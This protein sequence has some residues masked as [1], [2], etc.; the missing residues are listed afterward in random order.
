MLTDL[1]ERIPFTKEILLGTDIKVKNA[2]AIALNLGDLTYPQIVIRG[3]YIGGSDDL[4]ELIDK[5]II[6]NLLTMNRHLVGIN[7]TVATVGG[8]SDPSQTNTAI[9]WYEPL[10]KRSQTPE[11]LTIPGDSPYFSHW[12]FFQGYMYSNLVRYISIA[13]SIILALCLLLAPFASNT[14]SNTYHFLQIAISFLLI[15][16]LGILLFGPSPFSFSGVLSTYFGWKYKGNTTSS[17]PYKFVWLI[18]VASLAPFLFQNSLTSN[19][20]IATMT[21]TLTNSVVLVVFRF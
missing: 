9:I 8:R 6:E 10:L 12:Y 19:G 5:D 14:S 20:A 4:K 1:Q 16:I 18:Y 21:S 11:M 15:D 2:V 7:A 3:R 13:H 17:I